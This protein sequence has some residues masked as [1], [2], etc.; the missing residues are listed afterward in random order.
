MIPWEAKR[1]PK[2]KN[3]FGKLSNRKGND[4]YLA[5]PNFFREFSS[6]IRNIHLK[7]LF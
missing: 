1:E 6:E 4:L 3:V 7:W 5:T 2:Q